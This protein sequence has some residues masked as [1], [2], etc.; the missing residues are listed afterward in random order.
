[1]SVPAPTVPTPVHA[2][3]PAPVPEAPAG[4]E[5]DYSYY[6]DYSD[7]DYS[8]DDDD[9]PQAAPVLPAPSQPN[10]FPAAPGPPNQTLPNP[11]P[12]IPGPPSNQLPGAIPTA[13]RAPK[14]H[15]K[16]SRAPKANPKTPKGTAGKHIGT[17]YGDVRGRGSGRARDKMKQGRTR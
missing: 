3:V 12:P 15:P 9:G 17:R 6:D 8:Y 7:D 1:M 16:A 11:G 2:V 13:S 14:A 5:S 4:V 10:P